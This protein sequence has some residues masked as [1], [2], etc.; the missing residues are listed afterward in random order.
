ML[1]MRQKAVRYAVRPGVNRA[2]CRY[3]TGHHGNEGHE[4][5]HSSTEH[6]HHHAGPKDEPLGVSV[7]LFSIDAAADGAQIQL[8]IVLALI[9]ATYAIYH[10]SQ[11][12]ED[13]AR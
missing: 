4:V 9:P 7:N 10:L 5:K 11:T 13:G 6:G 1:A 12:S 3:S 8:Y 2:L